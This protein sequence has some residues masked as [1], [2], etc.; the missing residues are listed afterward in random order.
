MGKKRGKK[1]EKKA[2]RY[3]AMVEI[4]KLRDKL[5]FIVLDIVERRQRNNE[6]F[7]NPEDF[8][9]DYTR[10]IYGSNNTAK[11]TGSESSEVAGLEELQPEGSD[12]QKET[13]ERQGKTDAESENDN[14]QDSEKPPE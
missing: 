5:D 11:S 1:D 10:V 13:N 4:R 3:P 6:P 9:A 12:G 7:L 8:R 2:N 14:S